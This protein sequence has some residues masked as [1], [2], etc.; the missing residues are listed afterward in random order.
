MNK[1]TGILIIKMF[2]E[3]TVCHVIFLIYIIL[4]HFQDLAWA[5]SRFPDP[6]AS[7]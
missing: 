5:M 1:I 6:N 3:L 7:F 4:F 2:G